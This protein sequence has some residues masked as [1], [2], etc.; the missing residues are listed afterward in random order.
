MALY[1]NPANERQVPILSG[2]SMLKTPRTGVDI[3]TTWSLD[4][5]K[6]G[7]RADCVFPPFILLQYPL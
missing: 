2:A 3:F 5:P 4:F 1:E 6:L 7:A